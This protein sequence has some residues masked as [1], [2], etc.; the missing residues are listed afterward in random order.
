MIEKKFLYGLFLAGAVGTA[1]GVAQ[2]KDNCS[3]DAASTARINF[4]QKSSVA[5]KNNS[6]TKNTGEYL[7]TA[8]SWKVFGTVSRLNILYYNLGGDQF[9]PAKYVDTLTENSTQTLAA[10]GQINYIP[11]YGIVGWTSPETNHRMFA[12]KTYLH[13]T[14]VTIVKRQVLNGAV[15]YQ[16]SNKQWLDGKYVKII[17][18]TTR[19]E[20]TYQANSISP[21]TT[22]TVTQPAKPAAKKVTT[23]KAKVATTTKTTTPVKNYN[24]ASLNT[25][26]LNGI[27]AYRAKNGLR[28]LALSGSL[29]SGSLVRA[30]EEAQAIRQTGS[31]QSVNHLR[32]NGTKFSTEAN[33]RGFGSGLYGENLAVVNN[34]GSVQAVAQRFVALW[35]NSPGHRENILKARYTA[36]GVTA[37]QLPNGQYIGMQ[38]FA[39]R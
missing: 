17:H 39:G 32:P 21:A 23:T 13:N 19:S 33:L 38:E 12:G 10:T 5:V 29:Q 16:L 24:T 14:K 8:S 35:I 25:L 31:N 27:N 37:Y 6:L 18:E 26:I 9:V 30:N 1:L 4:V 3:V 20:K 7:K 36:T 15:W 28:A 34:Q 2:V 22:K 11:K